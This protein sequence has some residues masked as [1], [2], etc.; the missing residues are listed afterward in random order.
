MTFGM[1]N[2]WCTSASN[3]KLFIKIRD[4]RWLVAIVKN[5]STNY[6]E[7]CYGDSSWPSRPHH[8]IQFWGC[9]C[10]WW[11]AD[12]PQHQTLGDS[13]DHLHREWLLHTTTNVLGVTIK[14]RIEPCQNRTIQTIGQLQLPTHDAVVDLWQKQKIGPSLTRAAVSLP[15][16][17]IIRSGTTLQVCV[18]WVVGT[19]VCTTVAVVCVCVV[20]VDI[21]REVS[22]DGR[23]C[24]AARGSDAV[25]VQVEQSAAS[26]AVWREDE[27]RHVDTWSGRDEANIARAAATDD[28]N[29]SAAT[30][31]SVTPTH[32]PIVCSQS[33][34]HYI[35]ALSVFVH[36]LTE[37]KVVDCVSRFTVESFP[38]SLWYNYQWTHASVCVCVC[39]ADTWWCVSYKCL[40]LL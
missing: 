30:S 6:Y 35:L 16:T 22:S 25:L 7:I 9:Q 36:F 31:S 26:W 28:V 2:C 12:W 38:S 17:A 27:E 19:S 14:I 21:W 18:F 15:S 33:Q 34:S 5:W 40:P 20:N 8:P 37:C 24:N 13:A 23:V 32:R 11:K 10:T 39:M 4:G 29:V 1:L 3:K